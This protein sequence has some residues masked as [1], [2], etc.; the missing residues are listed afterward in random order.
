M[1]AVSSGNSFLLCGFNEYE[2]PACSSLFSGVLS[3][4]PKVVV[5]INKSFMISK[6]PMVF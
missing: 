3:E 2:I 6:K 1:S 4:A 5:D